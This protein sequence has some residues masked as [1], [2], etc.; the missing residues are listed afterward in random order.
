MVLFYLHILFD[1]VKKK[2]L[3]LAVKILVTVRFH[4]SLAL[5]GRQKCHEYSNDKKFFVYSG[6]Q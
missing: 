4:N 2:A 3:R 1:L 5:T 6:P